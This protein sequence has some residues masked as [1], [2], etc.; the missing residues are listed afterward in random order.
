MQAPRH[1][2]MQLMVATMTHQTKAL[3]LMRHSYIAKFIIG[4]LN[5]R[6]FN[7]IYFNQ[8]SLTQQ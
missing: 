1:Y 3:S 8:N 4:G 6:N 7:H 2:V 5:R